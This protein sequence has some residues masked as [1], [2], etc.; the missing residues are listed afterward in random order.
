MKAEHL[1]N[2]ILTAQSARRRRR[3]TLMAFL[4]GLGSAVLSLVI[5]EINSL[6]NP[7]IAE[8]EYLRTTTNEVKMLA[9]SVDA[10]EEMTD[11][12]LLN[13]IADDWIHFGH[14][15]RDPDEHFFVVNNADSQVILD[16]IYRGA[17]GTIPFA[18][19]L[20]DVAVAVREQ[21][22]NRLV[23]VRLL[24]SDPFTAG[25]ES[26]IGS[27]KN[28]SPPTSAQGRDW[29]LGIFRSRAGLHT[30]AAARFSLFGTLIAVCGLAMPISLLLMYYTHHLAQRDQTLAEQARARLAAVVQDSEDAIF[31][32]T[33]D[34]VI[35]SWNRGAE[36]LF[37]Y[38]ETE[39]LGRKS[40]D[41]I[42]CERSAEERQAIEQLVDGERADEGA[43]E[44]IRGCKD[45]KIVH[46]LQTI[47]PVNDDG[48][49]R[50]GVSIIARDVT[51]RKNLEREVLESAGR[52]QQRIGR[53]LHDSLGQ[54]L[55]GLSYLA[56]SLAQ[57]LAAAGSAHA[58]T[59]DLIA[60]GT[61]RALREVRSA[62]QGLV[63]VEV[64]ACGFMVAL[65]KLAA[66]TTI[67]CG[68]DCRIECP[69]PIQ[70][71]D[72]VLATHLF[73]IVQEAINNAVKHARAHQIVVRPESQN[74]TLRVTVEDDGVG[75]AEDARHNGGMGLRIMQYRA[76]VI[77]AALDVHSTEKGGTAVVCLVK[78]HP[79]RVP[80]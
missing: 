22:G 33:F 79:D 70:V 42:A 80:S 47:S 73:R 14:T 46:V 78:S 16:T 63:P 34:G 20:S 31:T 38:S 54:E 59:A 13:K 26:L 74:G 69:D 57:K 43:F 18:D 9:A 49:K 50:I 67:H 65:E 56:K 39:A 12:K 32:E 21:M 52:E 58:E 68:I 76:G 5:V 44:T 41:I 45:G 28:S 23:P 8:E 7:E 37:G 3:L 53:E 77:D 40:A 24:Y 36:R 35:T 25:G 55:T 11:D 61:Q 71:D 64:D 2:P 30:A 29:L 51:E 4:L 75:I 1:S 60:S 10:G 27:F 48:G 62:V 6:R 19:R 17:H 15:D 72:N 66:Q